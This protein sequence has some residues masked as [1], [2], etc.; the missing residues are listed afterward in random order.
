MYFTQGKMVASLAK[1]PSGRLLKHIVRC[2]LRLSDNAR[3]V[4]M[5]VYNLKAEL[6]TLKSCI[7]EAITVSSRVV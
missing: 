5:R 4:C 3:C 1:E 2:Y 6:L 7:S